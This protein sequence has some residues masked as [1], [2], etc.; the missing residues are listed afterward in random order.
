MKRLFLLLV[1]FSVPRLALAGEVDDL[2]KKG[3][4]LEVQMKTREALAPYLAAEKLQPKDANVLYRISRQ[5]AELMHD[6]TSKSEQAQPSQSSTRLCQTRRGHR[7][8]K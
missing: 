4:A 6:T 2:L 5:Y 8:Q 3:D 7:S 1:L